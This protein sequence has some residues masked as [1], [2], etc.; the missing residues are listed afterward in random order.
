M[1]ICQIESRDTT[2]SNSRTPLRTLKVY[3]DRYVVQDNLKLSTKMSQTQSITTQLLG[4]V[5]IVSLNRPDSFNAWT[6]AMYSRY[7]DILTSAATNT[8]V[9]CLL[10]RANG[11]NF[12]AGQDV[13]E[14]AQYPVGS[15]GAP[16]FDQMLRA[17]VTFPKPL[18]AAVQGL[19]IGWG[20]TLLATCDL[21]IMSTTAKIRLPFT[22]LGLAPEAGSSN[23]F[24]SL[25]KQDANWLL[26]SSE[27][28]HAVDCKRVGLAFKVVAPMNLL[29]QTMRHCHII[30][31]QPI[32]SLTATKRLIVQSSAESTLAAHEREQH[33]FANGLLGGKANVEALRALK[34]KRLADFSK[35]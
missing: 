1:S 27:Y 12:S 9:A 33:A 17:H 6:D 30:A 25:M 22:A 3:D 26:Y 24:P 21:V 31:A 23:T 13:K 18:I 34:E 19:A 32:A 16:S 29:D 28:M 4:R 10:L 14:L 2:R 20:A 7:H 35:L 8:S 15:T 5:M 11:K